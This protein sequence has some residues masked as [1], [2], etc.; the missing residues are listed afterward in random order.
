M[1]IRA[2]STPVVAFTDDDCLPAADWVTAL[3]A[4]FAAHPDAAFVTGRITLGEP[5]SGRMQLGLSIHD[6]T[7]PG[8]V[9]AGS[10]VSK[11]GHGAN[12]AWR[13]A[14]L[15]ALDGFDEGLGPGT[16]LGRPRITICSGG[17]CRPG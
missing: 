12:M 17:P 3:S 10:D 7:V 5:I 14:D 13:R 11:I 6:V 1:G 9:D 16:A 8:T 2:A 4:A 15:E